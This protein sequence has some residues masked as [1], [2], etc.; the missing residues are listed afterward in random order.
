MH[1]VTSFLLCVICY[2]YSFCLPILLL[3]TGFHSIDFSA[4]SE[5][6]SEIPTISNNKINGQFLH[7]MKMGKVTI[8]HSKF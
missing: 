3:Q 1:D 4:D 5:D 7:N 6:Q 2:I 8:F